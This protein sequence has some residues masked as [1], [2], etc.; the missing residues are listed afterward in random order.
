MNE[1]RRQQIREKYPD[2]DEARRERIYLEQT[3]RGEFSEEYL[4]GYET[5]LRARDAAPGETAE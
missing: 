1:Y 4:D 3:Y 2:A 5:F